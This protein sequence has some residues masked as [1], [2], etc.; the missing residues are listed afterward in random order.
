MVVVLE[1]SDEF[2]G[3][4]LDNF[5]LQMTRLGQHFVQLMH[6]YSQVGISEVPVYRVKHLRL[7]DGVLVQQLAT[8]SAVDGLIQDILK[9]EQKIGIKSFKK[10]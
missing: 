10:L 4:E 2:Y 6:R 3:I 5:K 9:P 7:I 8:I 1:D